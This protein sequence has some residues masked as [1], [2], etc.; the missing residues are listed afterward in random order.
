M[1]LIG[2][3]GRKAE[4]RER[5]FGREHL[6]ASGAD[7]K[8]VDVLADAFAN[9]AAEDTRKMNRMNAGFAGEFVESEP[10]AVFGFQFVEDASEPERGVPGFGA[11]PARTDGESLCKKSI[12]SEFVGSA[13][14]SDLAKELYAE[15]EER[16]AADVFAGSIESRGAVGKPPLPGRANLDFKKPDAARTNFVLMGNA[17]GAKHDGERAELGILPAVAFAVM[18]IQ[19]QRKKRKLVRVHREFA[20]SGVTQIGE[21]CATLLALA[22]DGTE[23]IACSHV[24]SVRHVV[25]R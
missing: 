16:A 12:H 15:P 18:A 14:G 1:A 24:L 7:S 3:A 23:E 5:G 10:A 2:E 8:P 20:R 21:D 22:V 13:A 19:K 6:L 25:S 9:A 11:R 4:V 17:G